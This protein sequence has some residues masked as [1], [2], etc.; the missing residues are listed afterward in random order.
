MSESYE[1]VTDSSDYVS[2]VMTDEA[3]GAADG[4]LTPF[5]SLTKSQKLK[6]LQSFNSGECEVM[7]HKSDESFR[8]KTISTFTEQIEPNIDVKPI[9]E[10]LT[11]KNSCCCLC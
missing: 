4:V 9:N 3:Q 7:S 2:S 11:D 6:I 5:P 1:Y 8:P 10:T